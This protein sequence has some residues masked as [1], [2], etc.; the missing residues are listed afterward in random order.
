MNNKL[1]QF[2]NVIIGYF[3]GIV[4]TISQRYNPL[5]VLF[6]LLKKIKNKNKKMHP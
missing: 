1:D 4:L 3:A 2:I 6:L 5:M